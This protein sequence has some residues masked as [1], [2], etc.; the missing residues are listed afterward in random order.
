MMMIFCK[1]D[2]IMTLRSIFIRRQRLL[3][4]PKPDN[5]DNDNNDNDNSNNDDDN[6]NRS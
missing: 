3:I 2:V 1:D 6:D 4:P 5:I